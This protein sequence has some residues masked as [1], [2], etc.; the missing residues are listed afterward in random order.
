MLEP[1]RDK[2]Q[3]FKKRKIRITSPTYFS[4]VLRGAK[5]TKRNPSR[6]STYLI[7]PSR[8]HRRDRFEAAKLWDS[9]GS[10][11]HRCFLHLQIG[12]TDA[13]IF[14]TM[15]FRSMGSVGREGG[16]VLYTCKYT[17]R[18]THKGKGETTRRVPDTKREERSTRPISSAA[19][20][21]SGEPRI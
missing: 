12:F 15:P 4:I 10:W 19:D 5:R 2:I 8:N 14:T 20:S 6:K 1:K 21:P 7:P 3:C 17:Q 11:F 18:C 13:Y 9:L 16:E